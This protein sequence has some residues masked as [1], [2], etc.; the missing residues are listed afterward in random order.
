MLRN[1]NSSVI[2]NILGF[3][4]HV[5]QILIEQEISLVHNMMLEHT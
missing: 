2:L 3:Y 5:L 4:T 1:K